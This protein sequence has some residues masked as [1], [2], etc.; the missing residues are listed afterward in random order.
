MAEPA[1]IAHEGA[2]PDRL[3]E[4]EARLERL[5][6]VIRDLHL[7]DAA[8]PSLAM[9]LDNALPAGLLNVRHDATVWLTLAGRTLMVLGGAY[10]LRAITESGRLPASAGVVIG[11][12][13]ALAWLGASGGSTAAA[14]SSASS[15]SSCI[16][17]RRASGPGAAAC[18]AG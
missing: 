14:A 5:E 3:S 8:S 11:L 7:P 1:A 9:S 17:A 2:M 13:Y 6:A 4:I 12:G 16:P 18:S 10:L 15:A